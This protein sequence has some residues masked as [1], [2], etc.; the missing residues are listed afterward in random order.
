MEKPAPGYSRL[1]ASLGHVSR[2]APQSPQVSG[3]IAAL[4]S[5]TAI[6]SNGQ[7]GTQS[8][9]PVHFSWSTFA[10]MKHLQS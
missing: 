7:D 1:I 2:H 10:A 4:L 9:Q 3:S 8:P 6:A 5:F